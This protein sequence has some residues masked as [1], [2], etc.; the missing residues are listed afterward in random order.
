VAAHDEVRLAPDFRCTYFPQGVAE[1]VDVTH[2]ASAAGRPID[3]V[4]SA[5][6]AEPDQ[7]VIPHQ[8][9]LSDPGTVWF[10]IEPVSLLDGAADPVEVQGRCRRRETINVCT[11]HW[12]DLPPEIGAYFGPIDD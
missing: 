4:Y 5:R 12:D 2:A 8:P 3:R 9:D 7:C 1:F 10:L 6:Q 11:H